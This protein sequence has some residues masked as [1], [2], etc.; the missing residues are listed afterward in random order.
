M[1]GGHF[2]YNQYKIGYIA[3]AIEEELARQGT[4]K[5]KEEL[6]CSKDYYNQYPEE[7]FY[8]TH[9]E[10]V[11]QIMRDAIPL[12]RKAEIYAQRID[13]YLS[14]DDGDDSLISRLK[15]DLE[16]LNG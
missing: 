16:K 6:W 13:W 1:S 2:D 3:D 11:Q 10:D 15:E 8:I 5:P 12:L 4:E 7:R 9:A 14:G